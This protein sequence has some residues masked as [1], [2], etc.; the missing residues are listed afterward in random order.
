MSAKHRMEHH[1]RAHKARGGK[2]MGEPPV[3]SSGKTAKVHE[4]EMNAQGSPEMKEAEDKTEAFKRG[5]HAHGK[6]PHHR[7]DR[8]HKAHGGAAHHGHHARKERKSGGRAS[9]FSSA[10]QLTERVSAGAGQGKESDGPK[11]TE[12][13]D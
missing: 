7:L 13:T 9:P 6:K 3:P 11:G 5:G 4:H 10:R 1:H 2:S 8:K 12:L